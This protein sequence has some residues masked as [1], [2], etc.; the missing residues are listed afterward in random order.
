MTFCFSSPLFDSAFDLLISIRNG[1]D[2]LAETQIT[3][4]NVWGSVWEMATAGHRHDSGN[5][6]AFKTASL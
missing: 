3:L 5:D 4:K 6:L 2:R 1:N